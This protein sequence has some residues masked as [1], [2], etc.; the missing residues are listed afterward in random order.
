MNTE[1]HKYHSGVGEEDKEEALHG[2]QERLETKVVDFIE[3]GRDMAR[4]VSEEGLDFT[5]SEAENKVIDK[6]V[7]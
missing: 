4:V 3:V 7:I 1:A 6:K 2:R 5:K